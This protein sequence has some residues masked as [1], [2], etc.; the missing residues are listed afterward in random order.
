MHGYA[1][2]HQAVKSFRIEFQFSAIKNGIPKCLDLV[3]SWMEKYFLKLNA[4]KSQVIV[5][6]PDSQSSKLLVQRVFLEDG[7]MI[8][9]S[10][11]AMNL[12]V[13]LDQNLTFGS[14]VDMVVRSGYKLLRDISSIR[15]FL[16]DDDVKSL[17]NSVVISRIDNC[18]SLY[19]GLSGF[20][21]SK[22]QRLQN[23][24]A[25]VIYGE[26][27]R[28]HVS[29]L[30]KKLHWLPIRQRIIFKV[31]CLIFKCMHNTAPSYLT[32]TLPEVI[33]NRF[34][35]IPRTKTSYG[36]HA[37]SRFGPIYWNAL[38]TALRDR[39]SI[40][41]FKS[42]L[43]HYLFSSSTEYFNSLNRYRNWI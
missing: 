8:S 9:L 18:N 12:G 40:A 15:K 23:S 31:L 33:E 37:F 24:C 28:D 26:R 3:S 25:R 16:S 6:L 1:D 30:L 20:N 14:Q 32:E 4:S 38:P 13:L 27:R 43:K 36:D 2:D 29:G 17:V 41:N 7:S 22:L 42:K 34:V 21:L 35:R 10:K 11:D 39:P 5:F 19:T